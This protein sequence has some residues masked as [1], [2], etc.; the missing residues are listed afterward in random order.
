M[1]KEGLV[2]ALGFIDNLLVIEVLINLSKDESSDIR[3]WATFYIGQ[4]ERNNKNIREALWQRINDNHQETKLEAISGLAKRKDKRVKEIITKEIINGEYGTL[5]FEAIVATQEIEFLPL[6]KQN[7]K[8]IK[9]KKTIN[10]K[11]E[12]DLKKCIN[13]LTRLRNKKRMTA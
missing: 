8:M 12:N 2:S 10:P 13:E 3:N 9:D 11:W 5:L 4:G 7:L 1:V 6:L